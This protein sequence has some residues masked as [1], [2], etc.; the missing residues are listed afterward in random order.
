MKP[1][2]YS[3]TSQSIAADVNWINMLLFFCNFALKYNTKA[4][5]PYIKQNGPYTVTTWLS[6]CPCLY[7][8]HI[9]SSIT[10]STF[11]IINSQKAF[12]YII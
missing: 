11:A 9:P 1:H 5:N 12:W 6:Q 7:K 8:H 10:P 3:T 4:P 2:I